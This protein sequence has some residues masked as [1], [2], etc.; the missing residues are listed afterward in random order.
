MHKRVFCEVPE[1]EM[2][3]AE[4]AEA[5]T[6]KSHVTTGTQGRCLFTASANF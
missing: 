2:A 6:E 3:L 4:V 1:A 5:E